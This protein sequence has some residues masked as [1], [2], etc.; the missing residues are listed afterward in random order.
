MSRRSSLPAC[1]Q[2]RQAT[3]WTYIFQ[4]LHAHL[5]GDPHGR[6]TPLVHTVVQ[7][8]DVFQPATNTGQDPNLSKPLVLG[9]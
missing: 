2:D 7:S 9:R 3:T 4:G 5:V 1:V 8:R 6:A